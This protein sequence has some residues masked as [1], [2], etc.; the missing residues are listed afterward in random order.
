M[1]RAMKPTDDQKERLFRDSVYYE[2][3]HTFGVPSDLT[4]EQLASHAVGETVNFS[5]HVHA[6][7]LAHF[8][9]RRPGDDEVPRKHDDSFAED[10]G[11]DPTVLGLSDDDR[12]KKAENKDLNKG[13]VHITYGRIGGATS[14]PWSSP[15]FKDLLPVTILFMKHISDN[16]SA[17]LAGGRNLFANPRE[18]KGWQQLLSCLESCQ[19]GQRLRFESGFSGQETWYVPRT[20]PGDLAALYGKK[21]APAPEEAVVLST[22]TNTADPRYQYFR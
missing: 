1:G 21:G 19:Q 15:V 13:L 14:K 18:R 22:A 3:I 6:R 9:F 7:A 10:F 20:E 5:R 16:E 17:G 4:D 11:F 2:I 8:L 12:K